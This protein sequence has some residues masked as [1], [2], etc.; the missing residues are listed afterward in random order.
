MQYPYAL[1]R[2]RV[3]ASFPQGLAE[4]PVDPA[5]LME[6]EPGPQRS[7]R[8]EPSFAAGLEGGTD[9]GGAELLELDG[10]ATAGEGGGE[11]A[12]M[13]PELSLMPPGGLEDAD[14]AREDSPT[15]AEGEPG[16]AT[17]APDLAPRDSAPSAERAASLQRVSG[18]LTRAAATLAA[19][20]PSP[21]PQPAAPPLGSVSRT[22]SRTVRVSAS[23]EVVA[24][25]GVE[26]GSA[27][28]DALPEPLAL[29]P[30]LEAAAEAEAAEAEAEAV[31]AEAEAAEAGKAGAAA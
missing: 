16:P 11:G 24:V 29:E 14:W 20:A 27:E 6:P 2:V 22:A 12:G 17:P 30:V 18:S 26:A 15:A 13:Q 1:V 25:E 31:E 3:S 28:A 5:T 19:R 4:E 21:S 10:P 8:P 23:G 7:P 9:G